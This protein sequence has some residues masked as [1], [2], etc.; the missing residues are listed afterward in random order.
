[1]I[2]HDRVLAYFELQILFN[3]Y[4]KQGHGHGTSFSKHWTQ[5]SGEV[6]KNKALK[7]KLLMCFGHSMF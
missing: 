7:D 6:D 3:A 4:N 2:Q 5:T 1:M